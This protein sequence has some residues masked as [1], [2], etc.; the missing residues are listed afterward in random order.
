MRFR[1]S[2]VSQ[3]GVLI[4]LGVAFI[5]GALA[6]E[7][8][9]ENSTERESAILRAERQLRRCEMRLVDEMQR[10]VERIDRAL[11]LFGDAARKNTNGTLWAFG[12]TGRP[13]A[14]LELYQGTEPNANWCNAVTLT[15]TS[16]VVMQTPQSGR[17]QPKQTQ[18]EP[19]PI[20]DAPPP[21]DK[22]EQ[23]LRQMKELARRFSSHEFWDPDNSR[24]E[25]RLLVQPVHRYRDR[26]LGIR[27][28]AAFVF[29]NGTNPEV[30]LMI[31]AIE[32]NETSSRWYYSV[33]RQ[34]SA[35]LHVELDSKEV[36]KQNR[37][38]GVVGTPD[39]PYW[40]FFSNAMSGD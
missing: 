21:R 34:G 10:P 3:A 12:R 25:L 28:G 36:W 6:G 15:G 27:D 11:L 32:Q 24:F 29:A 26:A 9:P 38:P 20:A 22:E 13:S 8:T 30:I 17:W 37:T 40:L 31:E 39:D 4:T 16:R 19:K 7:D 1:L 35:E 23:R 14:F 5:F 2:Q 33:A 18:I